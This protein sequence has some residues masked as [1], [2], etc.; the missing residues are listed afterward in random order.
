MPHP[1]NLGKITMDHLFGFATRYSLDDY[2]GGLE[3]IFK[4][5]KS[6]PETHFPSFFHLHNA[7]KH[8]EMIEIL[9]ET[10]SAERI[11][12]EIARI[13]IGVMDVD[14]SPYQKFYE[15][16]MVDIV[17]ATKS[18]PTTELLGLLNENT[19]NWALATMLRSF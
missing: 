1:T 14:D 3:M 15:T 10:N 18:K 17:R 4:P 19:D 5:G 16:Y 9:L 13:C 7:G 2:C 11:L 12:S 8:V 6:S